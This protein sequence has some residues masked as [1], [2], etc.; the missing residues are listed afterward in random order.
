MRGRGT[1]ALSCVRDERDHSEWMS[2]LT[3]T[4]N[5]ITPLKRIPGQKVMDGLIDQWA[6]RACQ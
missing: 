4:T 2:L 6:W 1:A 5:S 3:M